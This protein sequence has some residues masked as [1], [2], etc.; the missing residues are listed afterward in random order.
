MINETE[1]D[2]DAYTLFSISLVAV[3]LGIPLEES[4]S[5]AGLSIDDFMEE[6]FGVDSPFLAHQKKIYLNEFSQDNLFSKEGSKL[7]V[8]KKVFC[9]QRYAEEMRDTIIA[10]LPCANVINLIGPNQYLLGYKGTDPGI[11]FQL[12]RGVEVEQVLEKARD[13]HIWFNYSDS[14]FNADTIS[15]VDSLITEVILDPKKE[16]IEM[17]FNSLNKLS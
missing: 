8:V 17:I 10:S 15:E 7:Y 13:A 16:N 5:R 11:E 12:I 6:S 9:P 3:K 4:F 2:F 14:Y 1:T